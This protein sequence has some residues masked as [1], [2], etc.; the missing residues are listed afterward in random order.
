MGSNCSKVFT[1]QQGKQDSC[2][3]CKTTAPL[4]HTQKWKTA[5]MAHSSADYCVTTKGQC[6]RSGSKSRALS[7][8]LEINNFLEQ[9]LGR[10]A[11]LQTSL[12]PSQFPPFYLHFLELHW[13]WLPIYISLS[14]PILES[15]AEFTR[16]KWVL[17]NHRRQVSTGL[18]NISDVWISFI[19][20]RWGLPSVWAHNTKRYTR[21]S[22]QA[23]SY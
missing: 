22:N 6:R 1:T 20:M 9:I 2:S 3:H 14:Q 23:Y 7:L 21:S 11:V 17:R 8:L 13:P 4:S 18:D 5:S 10:W 12:L 16:C 15:P 19:P